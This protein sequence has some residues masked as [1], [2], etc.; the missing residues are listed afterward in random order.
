MD[1][2]SKI[3]RVFELKLA[4]LFVFFIILFIIL[5]SSNTYAWT[6]YTHEWICNRANLSKLDCAL[7]DNPKIQSEHPDIIF[8]NHHCA[9]NKFDCSARKI[10]DKYIGL[11]TPYARDF[12]AHLYA[13]SM[14]PVHWYSFDY[15]SCHKIFEDKVEAKLRASENIK[16]DILG[17]SIDF[18]VWN[19]TMQCSAK[20]GKNYTNVTLY[21]DNMYMDSVARYV[22]EQLHSDYSPKALKTYNLTPLFIVLLIFIILIFILFIYFGLKNKRTVSIKK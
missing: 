2:K 16:Y 17:S 10:A 20:E 19:I 15:D 4:I 1:I 14:V 12:A 3:I 6:G 8:K 21:V 18:S 7:A 11:S 5:Y 22:S 9:E 13:D